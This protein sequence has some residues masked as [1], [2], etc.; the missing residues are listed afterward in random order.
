MK[1]GNGLHWKSSA[2]EGIAATEARDVKFG[3]APMMPPEKLAA[4]IRNGN[5]KFIGKESGNASGY[6]ALYVFE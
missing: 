3:K 6:V 1:T 4:E 5:A 2:Y